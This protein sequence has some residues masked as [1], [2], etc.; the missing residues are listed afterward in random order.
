MGENRVAIIDYGLSNSK[1]VLNMIKWIG[2][3][4]TITSERSEIEASTHIVLPGVGAFDSG[5][6]NLENRNLI[7]TLNEEVVIKKKPVL[8]I[9]L[10]MQ[11]LL[12]ASEEGERRGLGWIKGRSRRFDFQDNKLKVPHMGWNYIRSGCKESILDGLDGS[13]FYFVHSYYADVASEFI[14][15]TTTYGS[16]FVS[17]ICKDNIFG[18]QFHPEKSHKHGMQL[19]RNFLGI[20]DEG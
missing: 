3:V 13:K 19:F 6:R 18:I 11:L 7:E 4:G 16:E 10:G 15:T 1:S 14:L 8:G 17:G 5:M 2:G 12:D 9:C 20:A